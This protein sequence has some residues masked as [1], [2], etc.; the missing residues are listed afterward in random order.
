[1][2][3]ISTK[4]KDLF[5]IELEPY[6]DN[7]GEFFRL[8]CKKELKSILLDN[9][10]KQINYSKSRNK[11]TVRGL[12]YQVYPHEEIKIFTCIKGRLFDVVVDIRKDSATY[13]EYHGIE[14]SPEKNNMI[15]VPAGFAH[16]F[17]TLEDDTQA[18]YMTTE[19]YVPEYEKIINYKDPKIGIKWPLLVSEI[20]EKDK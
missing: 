4:F 12:H 14:L 10:I 20:S 8:F 18:L 19:F 16:G 15:Y 17:Q 1:M 7:R 5:I 6:K 2:K 3:I 9:D 13:L 11:G